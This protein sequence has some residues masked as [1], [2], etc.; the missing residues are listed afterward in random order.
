MRPVDH[1]LNPS[2]LDRIPVNV[3]DVPL[4]I[5]I[6]QNHVRPKSALPNAAFSPLKPACRNPF[7]FLNSAGEL[8]FDQ[9]P[10]GRIIRIRGRQRP[11]TMQMFGQNHNSFQL[12]GVSRTHGPERRPERIDMFH[13]QSVSPTFGEIHREKPCCAGRLYTTIL[14]HTLTCVIE[15]FARPMRF[16]TAHNILWIRIRPYI[17]SAVPKSFIISHCPPPQIPVLDQ[18]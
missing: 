15:S 7:T 6:I 14:G 12:E 17:Y 1:S 9:A 13:Q 2:V 10:P 11:H 5:L 4:E 8:D 18:K 3:I 16:A